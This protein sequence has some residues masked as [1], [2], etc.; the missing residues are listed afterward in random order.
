MIVSITNQKLKSFYMGPWYNFLIHSVSNFLLHAWIMKYTRFFRDYCHGRTCNGHGTCYIDEDFPSNYRCSCDEHFYGDNCEYE[1]TC[2]SQGYAPTSDH[3]P[4]P[5]ILR[6]TRRFILMFFFRVDCQN[7]GSCQTVVDTYRCVCSDSG[8]FVGRHCDACHRNYIG[9]GC[10]VRD[11][12]V[13][14]QCQNGAR[15]INDPDN[16]RYTCRCTEGPS[17]LRIKLVTCVNSCW[18]CFSFQVTLELTASCTT[19]V[20]IL[21]WRVRMEAPVTRTM[22]FVNAIATT[23]GIG[24]NAQE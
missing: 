22:A 19:C 1:N 10:D 2:T 16:N 13:G 24:T 5:I 7:G 15:C 4:Y 17:S 18:V 9:E 23:R 21:M 12:C 11:H 8:H 3:I 6:L 14:H 20:I